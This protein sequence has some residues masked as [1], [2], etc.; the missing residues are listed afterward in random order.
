[1]AA[2]G[3]VIDWK[4]RLGILTGLGECA[5]QK[6]GGSLRRI[7]KLVPMPS[8]EIIF[9]RALINSPENPEPEPQFSAEKLVIVETDIHE[10]LSKQ[11]E[12]MYT[13][14]PGIIMPGRNGGPGPRPM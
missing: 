4:W 3:N 8:G 13:G 6:L 10:N 2:E 1:M 5:F 7:T 11:I 9:S 14:R 12:R